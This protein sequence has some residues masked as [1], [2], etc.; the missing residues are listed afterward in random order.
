MQR[1]SRSLSILL[2]S[3]LFFPTACKPK[4]PEKTKAPVAVELLRVHPQD[5]RVPFQVGGLLKAGETSIITAEI[6]GTIGKEFFREGDRVEKDEILLKF[7]PE[8]FALNRNAADAN[9]EKAEVRL[10]NFRKEYER[11]RQLLQEGFLSTEE[12]DQAKRQFESAKADLD[13][14]KVNLQQTE[15]DLRKTEVRSPLPGIVVSRY[16]EVGEQV[17]PGTPLFKV[18]DIR[19]LRI[20]AGVSEEQLLQVKEKQSVTVRIGPFGKKIFS[21]RVTRIGVPASQEGGTFP[22]EIGLPNP[23][24]LLKPGMVAQVLF[25]GKM[26]RGIF[27]IPRNALVK[28]LGRNRAWVVRNRKAAGIPITLGADFGFSVAVTKGLSD[29]DRVVVIGQDKLTEGTPVTLRKIS[30]ETDR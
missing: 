19:L 23:Q 14:A 15:R 6:N 24:G 18:A 22:V 27:L 29:G 26:H 20:I 9:R 11:R 25:P 21:G 3:L 8:P 12:V 2:L 28:Q 16:R 4:P 7:D 5:I 13:V 10:S 1:H 30:G 17:P